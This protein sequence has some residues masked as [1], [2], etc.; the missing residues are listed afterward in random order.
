M[1][2]IF[3]VT[4]NLQS[5]IALSKFSPLKFAIKPGENDG[6][7]PAPPVLVSSS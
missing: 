3:D 6:K 5:E 4:V 1:I 2:S 7:L